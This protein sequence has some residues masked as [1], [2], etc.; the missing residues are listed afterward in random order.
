MAV[1]SLILGIAGFFTGITSIVAIILGAIALNQIKRDPSQEGRGMAIAGII[2][3]S[4]VVVF[5][6]LAIAF[7]TVVFSNITTYDSDSWVRALALISP[8]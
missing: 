4:V 7:F 1:A 5:G 2:L 6:V 8:A 3:G